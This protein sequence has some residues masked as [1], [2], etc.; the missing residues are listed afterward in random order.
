MARLK[1]DNVQINISIPSEWK[2]EL[3]NLA[4]I[5]SVEEG[6][7]ITFLDLMLMCCKVTHKNLT[8]SSPYY[9]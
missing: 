1:S 9:S 6:E 2:K 3:E 4:R 8:G 7:T 5:Y